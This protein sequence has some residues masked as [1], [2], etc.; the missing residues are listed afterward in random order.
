MQL[1]QRSLELDIWEKETYHIFLSIP[2]KNEINT[3]PFIQKLNSLEKKVVVPKVKS[4]GLLEHF[5]LTRETRIETNSWGV[6]EPIS[7][8][9]INPK[10][11]DVV[12]VPLLIFDLDGYRVGYGG[13]YYDTFLSECETGVITVG[14]SLFEPIEKIEDVYIGDVPLDFVVCPEKVYRFNPRL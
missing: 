11:I 4:K 14:L 8:I 7:G 12:F 2:H 5:L 6:P 10:V 1:L 9:T 3:S 13:G